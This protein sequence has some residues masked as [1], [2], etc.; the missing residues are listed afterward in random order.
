MFHILVI[1][2]DILQPVSNLELPHPKTQNRERRNGPYIKV[3]FSDKY[4]SPPL[5]AH[6][7]KTAKP[8][9]FFSTRKTCSEGN[10]CRLY[11]LSMC[12]ISFRSNRHSIHDVEK[13]KWARKAD[14]QTDGTTPSQLPS[15]P[16]SLQKEL[17]TR[18]YYPITW[19][20]IGGGVMMGGYSKY[21]PSVAVILLTNISQ[22]YLARRSQQVTAQMAM[23]AGWLMRLKCGPLVSF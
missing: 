19:R 4:F 12:Y 17:K 13:S 10:K 7:N 11:V 2:K 23:I 8:C 3:S 6:H 9:K 1:I 18:D 20:V 15:T 21:P 5:V 16:R 14:S 22:G